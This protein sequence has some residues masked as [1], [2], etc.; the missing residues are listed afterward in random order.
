MGGLQA[1]LAEAA[2]EAGDV[3]VVGLTAGRIPKSAKTAEEVSN[4]SAWDDSTFSPPPASLPGRSP[5]VAN[6]ASVPSVVT[7]AAPAW[8]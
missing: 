6:P 7:R 8:A 3:R 5:R 2:A 4:T 1:E